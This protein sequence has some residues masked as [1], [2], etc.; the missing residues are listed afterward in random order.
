M[1]VRLQSLSVRPIMPQVDLSNSTLLTVSVMSPAY[2]V[3]EHYII[4]AIGHILLT[5]WICFSNTTI[6]ITIGMDPHLRI[7]PKNLLIVN[8]A[9]TELIVGLFCCPLYTDSLLHGTWR[10]SRGACITYE[11]VF[12][13]QVCISVLSV[14]IINVERFYYLLSPRMMDGSGKGILTSVLILLPWV[15]GVGLVAPMYSEGIAMNN[16]QTTDAGHCVILWKWKFQIVTC[17][18]SFFAPSFLVISMM[19]T[20]VIVYVIFGILAKRGNREVH[21]EEKP[22]RESLHTVLLASFVCVGMLFPVFFC[23]LMYLF[24]NSNNSSCIRS[25]TLWGITMYLAMIKS[26]VMPL[27]WLVSTDI[28]H[29]VLSTWNRNRCR[30]R[31]VLQRSYSFTLS[32]ASSTRSTDTSF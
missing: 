8:S 10:N 30:S 1:D 19:T 20:V 14:L 12:Y 22:C 26:G 28:R 29:A 15:I 16:L 9:V 32:L 5:L 11:L 25:D 31:P 7:V 6:I 13:I 27:V 3:P 4:L 2:P 24:C 21:T 17:F 18:A 23:L